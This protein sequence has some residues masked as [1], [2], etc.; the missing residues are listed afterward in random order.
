MSGLIKKVKSSV[1]ELIVFG[2]RVLVAVSGGSDSMALL[3]LLEHFSKIL[4]FKLFVAH[5]NHL[6]RGKESDEDARFVAEE[7]DKLSLPFFMGRIDVA[8]EK[9]H[10][11]SSFQESARILR[12]RFLGE[13]LL[14]IKGTKIALGHTA[15]DQVETILMN[16]CD[17]VV[18][19]HWIRW[20]S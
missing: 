12:Y 7:A 20:K 17:G 16:L 2:D 14:S 6:T 10:F 18:I 15:D 1:D 8:R 4:G 3:Y 5:L 19:F 11:K 13:T 9:S